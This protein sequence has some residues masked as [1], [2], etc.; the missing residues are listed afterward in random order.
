M[1]REIT[2]FQMFSAALDCIQPNFPPGILQGDP[3]FSHTAYN[4][5]DGASA[6]GPWNEGQAPW[7]K[8][9]T[10]EYVENPV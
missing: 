1:T 3:A 4:M 5:S 7:P 10:W 6:R 8:D 9:E 2:H